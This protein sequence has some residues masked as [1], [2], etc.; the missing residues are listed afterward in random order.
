MNIIF[1]V[2]FAFPV[3]FLVRRRGLAVV[4]FLAADAILFTF[5]TLGVLLDWLGPT[6]GMSGEA[7]GPKPSGFPVEYS[8]GELT[9]YGLVNLVVIVV[10][11]GLVVLGSRLAGRRAA[12]RTATAVA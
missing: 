6:Q 8:N 11:V 1:T 10:G 3:G 2:L 5:Q 4:G 9:A 12:R 7:F